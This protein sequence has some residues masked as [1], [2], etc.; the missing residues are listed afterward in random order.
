MLVDEL[1]VNPYVTVARAES[2]LDV[3]NP[4]ARQIVELLEREGLLEEV[5]GRSWRR[6]Y[7]SKPILKAIEHPPDES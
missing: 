1:F 6:V 3:T 2:I 4:T 7:L 5:S